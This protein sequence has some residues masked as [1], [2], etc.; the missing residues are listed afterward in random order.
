M[1]ENPRPTN[2]EPRRKLPGLPLPDL[3]AVLAL[4]AL[5]LLFFYKIALTNR[6][7]AGLDIFGYFYP[8]RDAVSEALRSGRLPL[9]NPTLYGGAPFV[10]DIQA[11]FEKVN[12]MLYQDARKLV[13]VVGAG[14]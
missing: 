9:W 5:I 8:Y 1:S 13:G 3:A 6:V 10:G 4:A 12:P 11:G 2:R 7:L 14:R